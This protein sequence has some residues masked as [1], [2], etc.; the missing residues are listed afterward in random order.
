[1]VTWTGRQVHIP[2]EGHYWPQ[3][4]VWPDGDNHLS[5]AIGTRRINAF[6]V[7]YNANV[8]G[9]SV[10]FTCATEVLPTV[11]WNDWLVQSNVTAPV[12]LA[13]SDPP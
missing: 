3:Y 9:N 5:G 13:P 10:E 6:G 12:D 7:P 4:T 11:T 8:P 2:K 1:M